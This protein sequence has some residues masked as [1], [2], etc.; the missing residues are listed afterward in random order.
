MG[1]AAFQLVYEYDFMIIK[2]NYN[3]GGNNRIALRFNISLI[4]LKR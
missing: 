1:A 2:P 4:E 3:F